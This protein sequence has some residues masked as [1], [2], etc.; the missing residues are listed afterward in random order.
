MSNIIPRFLFE[1]V[2]SVKKQFFVIAVDEVSALSIVRSASFSKKPD[3]EL[4]I[5][6][7]KIALNSSWD[8]KVN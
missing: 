4:S 7:K 6:G 1:V 5:A 3:E 8:L 2:D